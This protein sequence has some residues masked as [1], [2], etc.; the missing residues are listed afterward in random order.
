[1][2]YIYN[3]FW[4]PYWLCSSHTCDHTYTIIIRDITANRTDLHASSPKQTSNKLLQG[5]DLNLKALASDPVWHCDAC[6]LNLRKYLAVVVNP[7]LNPSIWID[8]KSGRSALVSQRNNSWSQIE[9]LLTF[10]PPKKALLG[11]HNA[12]IPTKYPNTC[13]SQHVAD[14]VIFIKANLKQ[15]IKGKQCSE[16]RQSHKNTKLRTE[17]RHNRL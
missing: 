14:G 16:S 11:L 2:I 9:R 15:T 7:S 1:M 17:P 5:W 4:C 6:P 3:R 10:L 13:L 12:L 8:F